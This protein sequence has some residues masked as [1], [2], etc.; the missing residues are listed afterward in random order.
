MLDFYDKNPPLKE[1]QEADPELPFCQI[2]GEYRMH[3]PKYN[4]I[5]LFD[6]MAETCPT[7]AP[8]YPRPDKC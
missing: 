8:F 5:K 7:M 6:N 4:S 3:L 1:C 2:H